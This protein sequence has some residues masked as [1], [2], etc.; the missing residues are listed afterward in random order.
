MAQIQWTEG[1]FLCCISLC[2]QFYLQQKPAKPFTEVLSKLQLQADLVA[3]L[4][5]LESYGRFDW[6]NQAKCAALPG[7]TLSGEVLTQA[8]LCLLG[9]IQKDT[10]NYSKKVQVICPNLNNYS[11]NHHLLSISNICW[12]Y[13]GQ[14]LIDFWKV[15]GGD[16]SSISYWM[17]G[18]VGR[19]I[20]LTPSSHFIW[21]LAE[22]MI[23]R[24]A[25]ICDVTFK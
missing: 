1:P 22:A 6:S 5:L 14:R 11:T 9:W 12:V 20:W 18:R 8:T 25:S 24:V 15:V 23:D 16:Q 4:I 3:H 10:Q 7:W 17:V 19:G 2:L 13:P 21:Y